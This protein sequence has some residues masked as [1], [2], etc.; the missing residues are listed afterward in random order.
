[1]GY[2]AIGKLNQPRRTLFV[3]IPRFSKIKI[4]IR[5]DSAAALAIFQDPYHGIIRL[6]PSDSH[7]DGIKDFFITAEGIDGSGK[8]YILKQTILERFANKKN[9]FIIR[10]RDFQKL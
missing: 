1:M 9:Y 3:L 10:K 6:P 2:M 7:P 5:S 4:T 8:L